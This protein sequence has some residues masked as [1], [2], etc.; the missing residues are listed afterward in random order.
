LKNGNF[1]KI[2]LEKLKIS[3]KLL[4]NNRNFSEICQEKSNLLLQGSTT[5]HISNQ[6]YAAASDLNRSRVVLELSYSLAQALTP[7]EI[8]PDE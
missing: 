4:A 1:S 6:I 5:P 3:S 7:V 2:F 8:D